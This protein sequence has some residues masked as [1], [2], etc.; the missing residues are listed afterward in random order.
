M[1]LTTLAHSFALLARGID[2]RGE[3]VPALAEIRDAMMAHPENVAGEGRLDTVLMR[4]M[5]TAI[6]S[7]AGA[8]GMHAVGH[9]GHGIGI[10]IKIAD[11][12]KRAVKPAVMAVLEHLSLLG[13]EDLNRIQPA[14]ELVIRNHAGLRVG[15]IR[16]APK[17]ERLGR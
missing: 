16:S 2:A 3:R 6:V 8:E 10:A 5:G 14:E 7:K 1:P 11:G 15:E 12:T 9:V 17:L 4:Q 13:P